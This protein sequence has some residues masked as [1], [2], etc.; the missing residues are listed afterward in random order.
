MTI[1]TK[2]LE[3][4]AAYWDEVAPEGAT[5]YDPVFNQF[6]LY[7]P[8]DVWNRWDC[9]GW[10]ICHDPGPHLKDK[11][12]PRQIKPAETEWDG[13]SV[14]MPGQRLKARAEQGNPWLTGTISY[15]SSSGVVFSPDDGGNELFWRYIN[16]TVE[17][18]PI[19][20]KEQRQRDEIS[21]VIAEAATLR[22]GTVLAD[23]QYDHIADAILSRY[24][25]EPKP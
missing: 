9:E 11:F 2:R 20:T 25:M 6:L 15:I 23:W 21:D 10:A 16:Y 4:D 13:N 8:C 5:H 24:A 22:A 12:I 1:D 17:F 18:R 19:R 14:I 7:F 3:T